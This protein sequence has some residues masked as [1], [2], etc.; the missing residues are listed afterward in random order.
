MPKVYKC[1]KMGSKRRRAKE[2]IAKEKRDKN[3]KYTEFSGKK[4]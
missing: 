3:R 4:Q 1:W 2:G